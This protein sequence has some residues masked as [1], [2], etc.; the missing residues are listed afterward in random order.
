MLRC[1]HFELLCD[2]WML[3]FEYVI[4]VSKFFAYITHLN[5]KTPQN[6]HNKPHA[7]VILGFD[8]MKLF[9]KKARIQ[10]LTR[11]C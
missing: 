7:A 11:N 1:H 5:E 4:L 2:Q 10:D 9:I 3:K 6:I 8:Q